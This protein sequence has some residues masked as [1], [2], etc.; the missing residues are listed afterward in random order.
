[1]LSL[2]M[3]TQLRRKARDFQALESRRKQAARL[4]ARGT[5][6]LAS[7]ARQLKVSRQSVSRWYQNWKQ[8]GMRGLHAAGRTGRLPRLNARQLQKGEAA[9][10]KGAVFHGFTA[11]RW[12]LPRVAT[13]IERLTGVRY[14][15][16]HV[17]KVL[18]S[19]KW[20][21]QKPAQQAKERDAERSHTGKACA[22]RR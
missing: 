11:D 12:T 17:G 20:S 19:R 16:G 8:S 3:L 4:F 14:H 18:G 1:M 2:C 21:S 6:R 10:K 13:V 15:P 7:V 9:L 5:V 22:G